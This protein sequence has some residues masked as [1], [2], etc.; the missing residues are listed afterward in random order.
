M[1]TTLAGVNNNIQKA[2]KLKGTGA[3]RA[4]GGKIVKVEDAD[5]AMVV[6]LRNGMSVGVSRN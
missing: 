4:E 5:K 2:K 1:G 3:S 6:A